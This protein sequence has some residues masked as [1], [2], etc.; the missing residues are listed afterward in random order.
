MERRFGHHAEVIGN[1]IGIDDKTKAILIERDQGLFYAEAIAQVALDD[2]EAAMALLSEGEDGYGQ[3][4][5][6][7]S[8]LRTLQQKLQP[9]VDAQQAESLANEAL[10]K[11]PTDY[12]AA[13]NSVKHEDKKVER[14]AQ[15][16]IRAARTEFNFQEAK[17]KKERITAGENSVYNPLIEGNHSEAMKAWGLLSPDDFSAAK[18][19]TMKA[20]IQKGLATTSNKAAEKL[21]RS[22]VVDGTIKTVYDLWSDP[23]T[24]LLTGPQMGTLQEFMEKQA[25]RPPGYAQAVNNVH[26]NFA[27]VFKDKLKKGE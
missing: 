9:K 12:D 10:L 17:A 13:L 7:K 1:A 19:L 27:S 26:S 4:I 18:R 16:I 2:P 8:I 3:F 11:N 25:K 15:S 24:K 20:T 6:D 5:K 14:A 22:K 23:D 21:M